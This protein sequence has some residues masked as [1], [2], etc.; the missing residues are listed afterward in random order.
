VHEIAARA[1]ARW[2]REVFEKDRERYAGL[3]A[4]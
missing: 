4:E 1:L 2:P 3:L